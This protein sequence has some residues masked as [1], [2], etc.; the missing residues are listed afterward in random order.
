MES[1]PLL[2]IYK[3]Y[4][5]IFYFML[6]TDHLIYLFLTLFTNIDS[7]QIYSNLASYI[8]LL[9]SIAPYRQEQ[10]TYLWK[11]PIQLKFYI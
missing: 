5:W 7:S 2:L 4:A 9:E 11:N 3:F 8:I 6:L 1:H 10:I